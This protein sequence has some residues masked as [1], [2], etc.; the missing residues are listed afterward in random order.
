MS[1]HPSDSLHGQDLWEVLGRYVAGEMGP[2]DAEQVRQWIGQDPSRRLLVDTLTNATE[3]LRARAPLGLDVE[4][5]LKRVRAERDNPKVFRLRDVREWSREWTAPLLRI[6]AVLTLAVSGT[7]LWQAFAGRLAA[8][9]KYVTE[10]GHTKT[11]KLRDQSWVLLGPSSRLVV[12]AGYFASG[13]EVTLTGEAYFD[14]RHNSAMPFRVH[15][16]N[17]EVQDLGTTFNVRSEGDGEVQVVVVSGSVAMQD[18][19]RGS[20][21][22]LLL[23]AGDRGIVLRDHATVS[24]HGVD[25]TAALAWTQGKVRFDNA[26]LSRVRTELRRW[27]G[28]ELDVSDSTLAS[29]HVT[30]SFGTE[31]V[32]R[33]VGIIALTVGATVE[34]HGDTM[35][36]KATHR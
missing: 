9:E 21:P 10:V 36:L 28:I 17:A 25:T 1:D 30:A 23:K 22:H 5:A 27:Y 13:R 11:I 6:A 32:G 16:G 19:T 33:V 3:G 15:A 14:V 31:P 29:R 2:E 24:E 35:V 18:T 26:P 8:A 20:R 34:Q 7:A 4:A 12:E